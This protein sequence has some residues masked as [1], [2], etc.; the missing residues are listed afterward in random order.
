[1]GKGHGEKLSRW[2]EVAIAALLSE[3]TLKLAAAEARVSERRL[4]AWLKRPDF[5]A[6]YASA[7]RRMLEHALSRLSRAAN[8]AV[9]TLTRALSCEK[10]SDRIRAALGVLD[11]ALAGA[12]LLDLDERMKE[13]ERK[14]GIDRDGRPLSP[15]GDG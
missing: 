14:L 13:I 10:P 9:T 6:A 15:G 2:Q 8:R 4:R 11:R 5:A 1:M 3:P 7:R 12:Q